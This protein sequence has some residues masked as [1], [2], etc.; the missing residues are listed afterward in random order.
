[1]QNLSIDFLFLEADFEVKREML[2]LYLINIGV[3]ELINGIPWHL[4]SI[5]LAL[6][7]IGSRGDHAMIS[8]VLHMIGI[9]I[10]VV[11]VMLSNRLYS[12]QRY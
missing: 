2:S 8:I 7:Q 6:L 1:M 5:I 10:I 11:L 4:D 9:L 3:G 12:K